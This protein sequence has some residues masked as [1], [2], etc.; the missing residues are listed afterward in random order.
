MRPM[1]T[2]DQQS[3]ERSL[4]QMSMEPAMLGSGLA[5]LVGGTVAVTIT[6]VPADAEF[7][8]QRKTQGSAPGELSF[9]VTTNTLTINSS[10]GSDDA[11]VRWY[12]VDA[13]TR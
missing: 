13:R 11:V 4:R 1:I 6:G 8:I 3:I 10:S 2:T 12:L 5:T 9:A 7:I